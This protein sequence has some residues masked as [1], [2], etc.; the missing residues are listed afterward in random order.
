[1]ITLSSQLDNYLRIRRGLGFALRTEERMLR[2]FIG[3][4]SSEG[5]ELLER[6]HFA[7]WMKN[8]GSAGQHTWYRRLGVVRLFATWLQANDSRHQI[9]PADLVPSRKRRP[10]PFIYT[11]AQIVRILEQA[12]KLPSTNGIRRLTYPTLFGLIAVTGLRI[13]EALSLDST[14][15]DFDERVVVVRKGKSGE[16]RIIPIC[17]STSLKLKNYARERDRLCEGKTTPFFVDDHGRRISDCAAR[18]NFASVTEA[19]GLRQRKRYQP[20]G[21][22]PRIHDLRHTFAVQTMIGW[23]RR[24]LDPDKEMIKLITILGHESM[25]HTYWYMEAIPELLD[26]ASQ[27]AELSLQRETFP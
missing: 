8:F 20:H 9:P 22:G 1:M 21:V 7:R 3:F 12:A 6:D 13:S 27:K 11:T 10:K 14:D 18:Y 16:Q 25:T 17:E 19:V 24:G 5:S 23:Y 2:R 26:L 4:V 15:I